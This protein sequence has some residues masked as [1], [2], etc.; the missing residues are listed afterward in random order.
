[1]FNGYDFIYDGK[2]SIS[3]NLKILRID[4][5][6][7]ESNQ[8]IPEQEI[9]LFHSN[10]S[11]KWQIS[12]IKYSEPLSFPIQILFHGD[13]EDKYEK[14]NPIL[15]RNLISRIT[16]WL[17][18]KT[19]YKRLQILSDDLRDLYFNAIFKDV[20]YLTNGGDIYGFSATVLCDTNG[21]WEEK[22]ITKAINDKA[23]IALQVLQDGFYEVEPVYAI[24][25]IDTSVTINVNGEDLVLNNV[26]AGSKITIDTARLIAKSSMGENLFV[27]N[28][29]KYNRCFPR[30]VYGRNVITVTGK[31]K[32]TINYKMVREVGC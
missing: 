23:T 27:K 25:M 19:G 15:E 2:S 28:E 5:S 29:N 17:F 21:A 31:C 4:G 8:A 20:E 14:R 18:D 1:M 13:G 6:A 16:H 32:L 10:Q 26:A 3:E 12:G 9:S 30:F 7:F 24:D 22:T 11:N